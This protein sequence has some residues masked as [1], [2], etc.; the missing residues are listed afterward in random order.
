MVSVAPRF[1]LSGMRALGRAPAGLSALVALACLA[2]AWHGRAS[3]AGEDKAGQARRAAAMKTFREQITPFLN[4]YCVECHGRNNRAKQGGVSFAG[5]FQR[6]GA[7]E[8]RKQWQLSM[9]NVKEH[10][11]PPPDA[12]SATRRCGRPP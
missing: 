2:F 6:P 3:A 9:V 11:M 7:G 12:A 8:L 4:K 10:V 5:A 1:R